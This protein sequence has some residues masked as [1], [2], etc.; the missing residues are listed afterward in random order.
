MDT[1]DIYRE[2][3]KYL[4]FEIEI[5]Q[6]RFFKESFYPQFNNPHVLTAV[7]PNLYGDNLVQNIHQRMDILD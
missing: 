2:V 7:C 3:H 1:T 5:H 6:A 4:L